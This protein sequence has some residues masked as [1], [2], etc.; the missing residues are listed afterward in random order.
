MPFGE[1]EPSIFHPCWQVILLLDT[2]KRACR[3]NAIVKRTR[4]RRGLLTGPTAATIVK[5][6]N[7][8][9]A[10]HLIVGRLL[11]FSTI[12]FVYQ[13]IYVQ[14]V[15]IRM[16]SSAGYVA[17]ASRGVVTLI[18][19]RTAGRHLTAKLGTHP[20]GARKINFSR[21]ARFTDH[22]SR[23]LTPSGRSC[24]VA[25]LIRVRGLM[26]CLI[27]VVI[28]RCAGKESWLFMSWSIRRWA[29][30]C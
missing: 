29:V 22:P 2:T 9:L 20:V 25:A 1:K 15:S 11:I 6:D 3:A 21:F 23:S 24:H 8:S 10:A 18:C 16:I 27:R 30:N 12:R 17:A 13:Q 28:V 4:V 5:L 14:R 19:S 26:T 7:L